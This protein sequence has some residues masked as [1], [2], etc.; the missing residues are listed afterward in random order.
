MRNNTIIPLSIPVISG[1][2]SDYIKKCLDSGY[3]VDGNFVSGFEKKVT[4]L[5][6]VKYA[7]ACSSGTAALHI[8]LLVSG[9]AEE[10][11][12]IV[13]TLTFIAPVNAIA[14]VGAKPVFMDCDEYL[15]I[16]AQ[17]TGEFI[18]K[19]CYFKKG[20]LVNRKTKRKVTAILPVHIF[21]H[22]ANIE[23][24]ME[25]SKTYNLKIIEDATESLGS[26]YISGKYKG[27]RTG[28]IGDTG[29]LSFNANKIITSAGGGMVLTNNYSLAERARYLIN[30]AKDDA[31]RYIHNSIGFNYRLSNLQSAFGLAQIER[32]AEFIGVKRRNFN[33]YQDGIKRITGLRLIEEP[34]YAFSNYW[35]YSLVIDPQKYGRSNIELAGV[36]KQHNIE[37]RPLW[38]LNHKQRPYKNCQSFN[39]QKAED[40]A[41]R[42]LSLPCSVNL[43]RKEILYV[44]EVLNQNA[45]A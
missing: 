29:C 27:K 36:L 45:K 30:Q 21:G 25:L 13:S 6:K 17:K 35:F 26:F 1:R 38:Y 10:D 14:Y 2:E 15:N 22:P 28:T 16:D 8:S 42:L 41:R 4:Q 18:R 24:L 39:I 9:I 34:E 31:F 37:A 11:E 32:L 33:I 44:T 19:E 23:P 40:A 3:V 12:V 20:R 5:L 43:E 7:V